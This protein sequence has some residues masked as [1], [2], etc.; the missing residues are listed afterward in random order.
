MSRERKE[1]PMAF[2]GGCHCG[3]VGFTVDADLPTEAMSCNCS[4]CRSKGLLLAFFPR[5]KVS[6]SGTEALKSYKFNRHAIDHLFCDTCGTEP[7]AA[8]TGRDGAEM[9][10][11]NLRCVPAAD[12]DV[13]T[14]RTFDGASV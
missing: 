12:L 6:I 7:F 4:I 10:A 14:I 13:L 9:E 3:R 11:I 5:E 2:S 1:D 8:A